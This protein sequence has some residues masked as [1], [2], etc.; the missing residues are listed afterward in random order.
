MCYLSSWQYRFEVGGANGRDEEKVCLPLLSEEKAG[1]GVTLWYEAYKSV[2]PSIAGTKGWW[3]RD[4]H[5]C[6]EHI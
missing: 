3:E 1:V 5:M 2:S 4:R 6:V